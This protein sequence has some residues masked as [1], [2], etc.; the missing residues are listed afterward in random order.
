VRVQERYSSLGELPGQRVL[1]T[2]YRD[3]LE[4]RRL[5]KALDKRGTARDKLIRNL[6]YHTQPVLSLSREGFQEFRGRAKSLSDEEIAE[7][8][9]KH[10]EARRV[11]TP[12]GPVTYETG[13]LL[14]ENIT[15]MIRIP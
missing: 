15:V 8:L 5:E 9:R 2:L 7:N 12:Q 10:V 11:G 4:V 14:Q 1:N 3:D 13:S 6:F